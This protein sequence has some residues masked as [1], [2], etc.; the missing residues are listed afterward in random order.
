LSSAPPTT[1][2]VPLLH[3]E[4]ARGAPDDERARL[5]RRAKLLAWGGLA[6]HGVEA[7]VAI[8]AGLVAG[9]IA[10]IG[11]GADSLIEALAGIVLL[12]RFAGTRVGSEWAEHRA[13]RL[14]AVTFLALTAYVGAEALHALIGRHEPNVSW[15]GIGLSAV[16]L[17]TMPPLA[18][19]KR[20]VGE[21]LG[22][23]ATK[24]ESRQTLLCAY[25][26]G[27][28][29][30]GLGANAVAGWWWA[31]PVTGLLIAAVAARE[32]RE[33]WRGESCCVGPVAVGHD[34]CSAS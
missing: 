22:S 25:L 14:I 6:W 27:A 19:A 12:W 13:H 32:G 17:A 23:A 4:R 21:R 10:L 31:D 2:T 9:S 20:R 18:A 8:G 30:V 7:G 28:L 11:F 1:P 33:A 15:V 29:L 26:S 34:D 5:V 3:V 24:S 16:T